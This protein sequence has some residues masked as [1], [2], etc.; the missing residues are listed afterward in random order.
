MM[1]QQTGF[2]S[3]LPRGH[4]CRS[5]SA[6]VGLKREMMDRGDKVKL[7]ESLSNTVRSGYRQ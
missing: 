5:L 6:R 3:E 7:L 1:N 4:Y 2:G